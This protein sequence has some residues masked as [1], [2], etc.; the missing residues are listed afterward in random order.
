M[1]FPGGSFFSICL[2]QKKKANEGVENEPYSSG[3]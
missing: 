3:E 2:E 1:M